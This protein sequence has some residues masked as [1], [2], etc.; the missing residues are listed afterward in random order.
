MASAR[1][2]TTLSGTRRSGPV[3]AKLSDGQFCMWIVLNLTPSSHLGQKRKKF[4]WTPLRW[5]LQNFALFFFPS[6][7]PF[8]L[9][10]SLSGCLLVE[11]VVGAS[12]EN[13]HI[14][15]PRRFKHHQNS[16]RRPPKREEK[17]EFCVGRGKKKRGISGAPPFGGFTLRGLTGVN[18]FML[19]FHLVFLFF[20]FLMRPKH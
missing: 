5:T 19:H 6:P 4:P 11:F 17:N 9:F 12:H 1:C 20:F 18:S 8:L 2:S 10:L 13:V 7:R 14:S 16:T 3:S 15:G